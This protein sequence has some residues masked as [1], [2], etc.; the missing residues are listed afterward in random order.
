M[1]PCLQLLLVVF[2]ISSPA[3]S[4]ADQP[5]N[6]DK[7][8]QIKS[9]IRH[10][11]PEHK[12]APQQQKSQS[13][14]QAKELPRATPQQIKSQSHHQAPEQPKATPQQQI[15]P[16]PS[17]RIPEQPRVAPQQQ[18]KSK[19]RIHKLDQTKIQQQ[20]RFTP[21]SPSLSR[22]PPHSK[23]LDKLPHS[24]EKK[25]KLETLKQQTYRF[26]SSQDSKKNIKDLQS[27]VRNKIDT[28][29]KISQQASSHVKHN[30]PHSRQWFNRNFFQNHNYHPNYWNQHTNWWRGAKWHR[31]HNWLGWGA[32]VYPIYYDEGGYPIPI[33]DWDHEYAQNDLSIGEEDWLPIG[34][35]ALG[36]NANQATYSNLFV[37]LAINRQG[38]IAGTYYNASTDMD[39]PIE[40]G[41]DPQT[42]QIY[43]MIALGTPPQIMT[44]GIYNLTQDVVPIQITFQ[45]GIAQNWVLVRINE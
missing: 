33:T 15:K 13:R 42:Q 43:C 28:H 2:A 6:K 5:Q 36:A 44:T 35:F 34:V 32:A 14:H 16:K 29:G 10:Q 9:E 37:Q 30:H 17:H 11:Q 19:P 21:R 4:Q 25:Q 39:Y 7:E 20:T 23:Q 41:V 31:I 38:D 24:F 27:S 8:K 26:Q 45:R 1:K 40:G 22:L 18:I 12:V 3:D